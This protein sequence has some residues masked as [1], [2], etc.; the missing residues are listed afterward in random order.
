MSETE[1]PKAWVTIYDE[2]GDRSGTLS[3]NKEGLEILK[4]KIDEAIEKGDVGTEPELDS[5]FLEVRFEENR[6]ELDEKETTKD[7]VFKYGC[8]ALGLVLL[9]VFGFGIKGIYDLL[10]AK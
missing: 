2:Y 1:K 3:G 10:S 5:D 6:K 7:Q 4:K 8:L 9:I